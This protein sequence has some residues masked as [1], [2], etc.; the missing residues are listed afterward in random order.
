[1]GNQLVGTPLDQMLVYCVHHK[2]SEKIDIGTVAKLLELDP[3]SVNTVYHYHIP[4]TAQQRAMVST[5]L[6][7]AILLKRMDLVE[8]LLQKGADIFATPSFNSPSV[9]FEYFEFGTTRVLSWFLDDYLSLKDIPA[10]VKRVLEAD[11]LQESVVELFKVGVKRHPAH[12]VLTCGNQ[13]IIEKF[14]AQYPRED[15]LNVEDPS[16]KTALQVATE[17]NNL[18]SVKVLL[19]L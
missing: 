4:T 14:L 13:D 18:A 17:Q 12:A 2:C 3:T 5:P 7:F 16:G 8:L 15:L 9:I 11:I 10:F 19:N 1:M 6:E